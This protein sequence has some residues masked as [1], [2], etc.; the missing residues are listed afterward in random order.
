MAACV[1]DVIRVV[2]RGERRSGMRVLHPP[3]RPDAGIMQNSQILKPCN[4]QKID[5]MTGS[6]DVLQ[7]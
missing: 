6:H 4:S 1:P 3:P 7:D 5:H 2:V